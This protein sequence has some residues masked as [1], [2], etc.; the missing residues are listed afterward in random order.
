MCATHQP[1][2]AGC[3]ATHVPARPPRPAPRRVRL[4]LVQHPA[5]DDG[6]LYDERD[7]VDDLVD[8]A[9]V[10]LERGRALP[11]LGQAVQQRLVAGRAQV[12]HL[13]LDAVVV[14]HAAGVQRVARRL[15]GAAAVHDA[16]VLAVP[17]ERR[18][19]AVVRLA[20]AAARLLLARVVAG[21]LDADIERGGGRREEGRADKGAGDHRE[22]PGTA[23]LHRPHG[24][25]RTKSLSPT[26]R[27]H[28]LALSGLVWSGLS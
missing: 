12:V 17:Q 24:S 15:A 4:G 8:H 27:W 5:G 19:R 16:A 6:G 7:H 10:P 11:Q 23:P 28:A 18:R 1:Q 25:S 13:C 21:G 9:P 20:R 2:G 22:P 3:C 26:A 14:V